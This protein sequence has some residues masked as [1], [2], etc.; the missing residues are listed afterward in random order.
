MPDRA[1]LIYA[2]EIINRIEE[3]AELP[4]LAAE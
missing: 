2:A 4:G 3:L 1:S